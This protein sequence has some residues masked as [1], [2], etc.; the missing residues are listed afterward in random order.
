M[1]L[2]V[3]FFLQSQYKCRHRKPT[4]PKIRLEHRYGKY[5]LGIYMRG[6][7]NVRGNC[8]AEVSPIRSEAKCHFM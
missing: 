5:Y 6:Q 3:F 8:G 1:E 4:D 7:S 2:R